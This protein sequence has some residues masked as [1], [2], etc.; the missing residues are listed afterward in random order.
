MAEPCQPPVQRRGPV[1][2]VIPRANNA[3][4]PRQP[5]DRY[6]EISAVWKIDL[7]NVDAL[8]AQEVSQSPRFRKGLRPA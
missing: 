3:R 6:A 8:S 5:S 7:Q 4:H 1:A 2:D